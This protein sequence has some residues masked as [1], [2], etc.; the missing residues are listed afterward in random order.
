MN[1]ERKHRIA[2]LPRL[3]A[4]CALL[5][6]FAQPALAQGE[7]SLAPQGGKVSASATVTFRIV[8]PEAVRMDARD[9]VAEVAPADRRSP[10]QQRRVDEFDGIQRVTLARP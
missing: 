9:L 3:A 5:L 1:V 8:V 7:V 10:P 4:L 2:K 6:A